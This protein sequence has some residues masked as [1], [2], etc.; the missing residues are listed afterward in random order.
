MNHVYP[1]EF[2]PVLSE[3]AS[4]MYGDFFWPDM[5]SNNSMKKSKYTKCLNFAKSLSKFPNNP[6]I[7]GILLN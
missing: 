4:D 6:S 3:S 5:K 7:R 1:S 2:W